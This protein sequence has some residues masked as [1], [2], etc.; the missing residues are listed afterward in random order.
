MDEFL[1]V[2][3]CK[4]R[5]IG[6]KLCRKKAKRKRVPESRQPL[7][8]QALLPGELKFRAITAYTVYLYGRKHTVLKHL[9]YRHII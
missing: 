9:P 8:K 3:T 5:V 7:A 1:L 2:Q 6:E 4:N